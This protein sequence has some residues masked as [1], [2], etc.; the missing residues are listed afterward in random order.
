MVLQLPT[1]YGRCHLASDRVALR[2]DQVAF[3]FNLRW[4]LPPALLG[5]GQAKAGLTS[6]ELK[7]SG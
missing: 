7:R 3:T 1:P 6:N 5:P 4:P 2:F